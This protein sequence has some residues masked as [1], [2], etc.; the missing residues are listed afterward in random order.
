MRRQRQHG[1]RENRCCSRRPSP[2]RR[3]RARSRGASRSAG[4]AGAGNDIELVARVHDHVAVVHAVNEL[5][6]R[7]RTACGS[8]RGRASGWPVARSA[9]RG[10]L[11]RRSRRDSVFENAAIAQVRRAD[12]A[13]SFRVRTALRTSRCRSPSRPP[14]SCAAARDGHCRPAAQVH[15]H[16]LVLARGE[17]EVGRRDDPAAFGVLGLERQAARPDPAALADGDVDA[18]VGRI[19]PALRDETRRLGRARRWPSRVRPDRTSTK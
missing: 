6:R 11:R 19:D 15:Q 8:R 18:A 17:A 2:S 10:R 1:L 16:R 14:C 3:Q 9:R 7:R 4:G 13:Q 12:A 5:A